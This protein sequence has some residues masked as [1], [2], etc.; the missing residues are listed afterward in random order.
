MK[1]CGECNT[2]QSVDNDVCQQCSSARLAER[3]RRVHGWVGIS[4][5][6]QGKEFGI[7]FLR[8]GRKILRF[9]RSLFEWVDPDDASGAA[10]VEYPIETPPNKGR[11][12]GEMHLDH[13]PVIYTKDA[14]DFT[15]RGWRTAVRI[16][17]GETSL[18]PNTAKARGDEPNDSPLARLHR[19]YRRNDPGTGYLTAGDGNSRMDTSDWVAAF[20]RGESDY[21]T[22]EKWWEAAV[23]HDRIKEQE[24]L[25]K[26]RRKRE[27]AENDREEREDP[28]TEFFDGSDATQDAESHEPDSQPAPPLT[29]QQ[30]IE[31][32]E[33]AGRPMRQLDGEY[34]AKGVGIRPVPL[35]VIA[36]RGVAV[37]GSDG[38]A[39]P[40]HLVSRAKG[41]FTA[42]VDLSHPL[43]ASFDDAPEDIVLF[44]L[45]QMMV[46]RAKSSVPVAAVYAELKERY[47]PGRA[48]SA[49]SL[50]AEANQLLSDVQARMSALVSDDPSRPWH[51]ALA[52]HERALARERVVDALKTSEFE[53]VISSGEYL[54]YVPPSAVPRIV[55]EWPDAFL[56][57]R[58]FSRPY[59][60]LEAAAQQQVLGRIVGYLNDAAWLASSPVG[61]D[62][63]EL[64]RARL[65]VE[66]LP[67]E[68]ASTLS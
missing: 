11:I 31:R 14:F 18:L 51:K 9:D 10:V 60:G 56:D 7:D 53:S 8:N 39:V 45:A 27:Q 46:V 20:H 65:S 15:D 29:E 61:A 63:D 16:I 50:Q 4:R 6:L 24:K 12:V 26:E 66:L 25:E 41:A 35:N 36:V 54:P 57:G 49:S 40:V 34:T 44:A 17:R 37:L 33:A 52:D 38:D 3:E 32:W 55:S 64:L 68:F 19:G 67:E 2:W 47:L 62:R 48:L 30:L 13:V 1:V 23:E 43:F 5:E 21:R 28:T 58:L 22:D 42:F 59:R